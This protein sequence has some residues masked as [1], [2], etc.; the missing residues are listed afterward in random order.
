M[1][2]SPSF[3]LASW[4]FFVGIQFI[5]WGLIFQ[6]FA[7]YT[8]P[9]PSPKKAP[10][11]VSV[12]LCARNEATNLQNNLELILTQDYPIFEVIVVNDDSSDET[13]AILAHFNQKYKHLKVIGVT[14]KKQMGKKAALSR[15]IKAA[16]YDWVLLTDADC[17]PQSPYWI[18]QMQLG[19]ADQT[20]IILGYGPYIAE[21]TAVNCWVQ[22]ETIYV[23]IQYFS[24]A[25]WQMP[26][27]GVGRNLMYKKILFEQQNGFASHAHLMSG[28]DDLFIH[29]AATSQNT[30]IEIDKNSFMYSAAPSSWGKLYQQKNR[31]YSSSSHYQWYFKLILGLLSLSHSIFYLG[32]FFFIIYNIWNP[33]FLAILIAR[34]FLVYFVFAKAAKK[35]YQLKILPYLWFMDMLLPFY[36]MI[37]ALATLGIQNKK[38]K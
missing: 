34:I 1:T 36:Y 6:R 3:F 11:A 30:Q 27:M 31:H 38:W 25:L 21:P 16:Q 8:K 7:W 26:Y 35:L 37:F 9:R 18:G 2:F 12:I 19:A 32:Y 4:Y 15:G 23:A 14:Q 29:Q 17:R 22:Y 13:A 20:E 24:L 28:D 5:Y 33:I 10:L